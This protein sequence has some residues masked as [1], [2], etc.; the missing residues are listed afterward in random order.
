MPQ[1]EAI[2]IKRFRR[3]P[4]DA[5]EMARLVAGWGIVGNANQGGRRQVTILSREAWQR[6]VDEV[7]LQV[8]ASARRANLMVSGVE[9][10]NSRDRVLCVGACRIRIG[11]ETRPC[12]RMDVA[13]EGLR[14]ALDPEWRGGAYGVVLNDAEI[15]V[16]DPVMWEESEEPSQAPRPDG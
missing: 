15:R 2:W 7:G 12:S 11:G 4:M 1:L 3:G 13:M 16:G 9:L 10:R 6:A 14:D 8:D 5:A